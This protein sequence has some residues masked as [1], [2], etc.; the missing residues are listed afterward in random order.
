MVNNHFVAVLPF[1]LR[2]FKVVDLRRCGLCKE[3]GQT[4]K[5]AGV[6][7][8]ADWQA[9]ITCSGTKE[10]GPRIAGRFLWIG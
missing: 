1:G 6:L 7:P 2:G 4:Q 5:N 8:R 3:A 9:G 10:N